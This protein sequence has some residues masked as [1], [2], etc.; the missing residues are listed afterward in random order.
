M[1]G[2]GTHPLRREVHPPAAGGDGGLRVDRRDRHP[3]RHST[4]S[5]SA[6]RSCSRTSTPGPSA[7]SRRA[8]S[9]PRCGCSAR[10]PPRG[11]SGR[12]ARSLGSPWSRCR[13]SPSPSPSRSRSPG[14]S[15]ARWRW[16]RSSGSSSGSCPG[17]GRSS[18]TT[19]HLGFLAAVATSVIGGV[20][21][22]LLATKIATGRDVIPDGGE[23]AHPATMVVGF[24]IPVGMALA[25][26]GLRG[27]RL[28]AAGRLGPLPD[29]PAVPGRRRCSMLG[30][31]LRHRP[32]PAAR[33]LIELVGVVIFVIRM[34]PDLRRR[35]VGR[36]DAEAVRGGV[37]ARPS[38]PTSSSSTTWPAPTRATSTSCPPTRSSPS[39]T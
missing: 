21:G 32:A 37:G 28:P 33:R 8:C 20:L 5:T 15:S 14:R 24:L 13:S 35:A 4:S 22:V 19:V 39:T 9:P 12:P 27:S 26:W 2:T 38:S 23:D 6:R 34:R 36:A 11:S 17:P 1:G 10:P 30:L 31:L 3:E 18:C 16:P 7:G 29:R 25:E